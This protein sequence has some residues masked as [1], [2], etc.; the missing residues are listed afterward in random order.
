[1]IIVKCIRSVFP[2]CELKVILHLPQRIFTI[3]PEISESITKSR[4]LPVAVDESIESYFSAES[5]GPGF[6]TLAVIMQAR[7][8]R[9]NKVTLISGRWLFASCSLSPIFS[10]V[11]QVF[12]LVFLMEDIRIVVEIFLFCGSALISKLHSSL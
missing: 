4:P 10:L 12:V 5:D 7:P 11:L 6:F 1:M 3:F 9:N 2:I 8:G